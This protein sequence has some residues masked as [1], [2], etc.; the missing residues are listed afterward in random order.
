MDTE[1]RFEGIIQHGPSEKSLARF[2]TQTSKVVTFSFI[3]AHTTNFVSRF[4][5][6][7]IIFLITRTRT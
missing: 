2:T 1:E 3:T 7:C 5:V 6:R 4:V